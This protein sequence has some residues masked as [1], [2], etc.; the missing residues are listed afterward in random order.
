MLKTLHQKIGLSERITFMYLD[1]EKVVGIAD[2]SSSDTEGATLG[3]LFVL[4]S[5]RGRGIGGKL[6]KAAKKHVLLHSTS[7]WV[8]VE[9]D[10]WC[11]DWYARLGFRDTGEL[12]GTRLWME[13][14]KDYKTL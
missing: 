2:V 13:W 5:H 14:Q 6:V 10:S 4:R 3:N 9:V 8:I 11:R 1:G 7:L 12:A